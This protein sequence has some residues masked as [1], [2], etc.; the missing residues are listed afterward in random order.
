M[1]EGFGGSGRGNGSGGEIGVNGGGGGV[2]GGGSGVTG[3]GSGMNGGGIG[4]NSG[5]SD[6]KG[7]ALSVEAISD[8]A[9]SC[10]ARGGAWQTPREAGPGVPDEV[11]RPQ[12]AAMPRLAPRPAGGRQKGAWKGERAHARRVRGSRAHA[13]SIAFPPLGRAV[14]TAT[15]PR[16]RAVHRRSVQGGRLTRGAQKSGGGAVV[17]ACACIAVRSGAGDTGCV[18]GSSSCWDAAAAEVLL[19]R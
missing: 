16:S 10:R 8:E 13:Q 7:E 17:G 9:R 1:L 4:V 3:G 12:A 19:S 18:G 5:G 14:Y 11:A 2:N 6:V 15:P